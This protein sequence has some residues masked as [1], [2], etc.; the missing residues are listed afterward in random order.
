MKHLNSFTEDMSEEQL[1]KLHK[2]EIDMFDKAYRVVSSVNS[3]KQHKCVLKYLHNYYRITKDYKLY[4]ILLKKL[5]N[6]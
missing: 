3:E 2:R 5:K 4:S 6:T 1:N